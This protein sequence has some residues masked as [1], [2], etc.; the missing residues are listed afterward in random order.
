MPASCLISRIFFSGLN[1]CRFYACGHRLSEFRH[2]T[3][4][5]S[6]WNLALR[7]F[8]PP[9]RHR[10]LRTLGGLF[11]YLMFIGFFVC[12]LVFPKVGG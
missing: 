3:G 1:L 11:V 9:L 6:A 5:L 4:E 2:V 8:P 12:L 10:S 7:I